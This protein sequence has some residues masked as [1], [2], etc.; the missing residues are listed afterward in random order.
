M[1]N[2]FGLLFS[3]FL[4]GTNVFGQ[5]NNQVSFYRIRTCSLLWRWFVVPED[6]LFIH[7]TCLFTFTMIKLETLVVSCFIDKF[8]TSSSSSCRWLLIHIFQKVKRYPNQK[9]QWDCLNASIEPSAYEF[10]WTYWIFGWTAGAADT[11]GAVW[12]ALQSLP[13]HSCCPHVSEAPNV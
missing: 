6:V 1:L 12:K 7:F 5:E 8:V 2:T 13:S 11:T 3:V 10:R 4:Q 9:T